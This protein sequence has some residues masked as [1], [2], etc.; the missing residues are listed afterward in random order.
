MLVEK[1]E[2]LKV[3]DRDLA[4]LV[5]VNELEEIQHTDEYKQKIY[6]VLAKL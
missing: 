2:T 4:D 1:V 5:P 6:G 3:L